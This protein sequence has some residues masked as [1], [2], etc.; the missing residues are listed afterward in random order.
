MS[1]ETFR[2]AAIMLLAGV[3]IPLMAALNT[4][5]GKGI[6]SPAAAATVLFT[7]ALIAS[8]TAMMLTS[9]P[10]PLR[11]VP[12]QPIFLL[13]AGLGVVFYVLSVTWI[14]PRFG[15]GNA[16]FC[17]LLGQMIAATA[18]DHFG[19]FGA[20]VKPLGMLRASGI[21]FMILGILLIQKA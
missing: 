13:F 7:V 19:L 2:Y 1:P 12:S 4:Q 14:A 10:Q 5:L 15:I 6:G 17:V 11:L 3:G 18:I 9:G 20:V 16:I 21:G 8:A